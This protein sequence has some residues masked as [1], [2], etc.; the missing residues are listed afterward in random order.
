MDGWMSDSNHMM[1]NFICQLDWAMRHTNIWSNTF[2][3]VFMSM[4]LDEIDILS[5]KLSKADCPI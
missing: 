3:C 2:L 5:S 1:V 4:F